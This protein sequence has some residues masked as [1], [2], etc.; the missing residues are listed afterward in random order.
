MQTLHEAPTTLEQQTPLDRVASLNDSLRRIGISAEVPSGVVEEIELTW[1]GKHEELFAAEA[2]LQAMIMSPGDGPGSST[3]ESG[4]LRI[5][6]DQINSFFE[7]SLTGLSGSVEDRDM[8]GNFIK[9]ATDM[10]AQNGLHS[11]LPVSHV[12]ERIAVE[13]SVEGYFVR[14]ISEAASTLLE[15]AGVRISSG[16]MPV[17][18]FTPRL[19]K[20]I[21]EGKIHPASSGQVVIATGSHS[22]GTH[23]TKVLEDRPKDALDYLGYATHQ[24]G[25]GCVTDARHQ[26]DTLKGA[27]IF[28]EADIIANNP[29][30][31]QTDDGTAGQGIDI[32]Y[33]DSSGHDASF[34]TDDAMFEVVSNN[35]VGYKRLFEPTLAQFQTG[36]NFHAPNNVEALKKLGIDSTVAKRQLLSEH[37]PSYL[38][39]PS[40][41][42]SDEIMASIAKRARERFGNSGTIVVPLRVANKSEMPKGLEPMDRAYADEAR[43]EK[44]VVLEL[45]K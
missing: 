2:G 9:R 17:V 28:R 38:E 26:P 19:H 3:D 15:R 24:R 1:Q 8:L 16:D 37:S 27:V 12:K 41:S 44:C 36:V 14:H 33:Y 32:V 6:T 5:V 20:I 13:E 34:S 25:H 40:G 4:Q 22:K 11:L 43:L 35:M 23:F 30:R 7:P 45:V 31:R 10:L 21:P 39:P 18:T 29:Y 42:Y